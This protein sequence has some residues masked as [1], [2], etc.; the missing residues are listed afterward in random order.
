MEPAKPSSGQHRSKR[1]LGDGPSRGVFEKQEDHLGKAAVAKHAAKQAIRE[2][3]FGDAWRLLHDQ[4][5]EWL[6]HASRE[7]FIHQQMLSLLASIHKDMANVL[8]LEDKQGEALAHILYCVASSSRPTQAQQKKLASYFRRCKF[9]C[10]SD[11]QAATAAKELKANPDFQ[12]A[13]EIVAS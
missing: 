8:R 11:S 2:K 7:R 13:Q 5:C 12:A 1:D 4:Q 10:L 3:R 6:Q 9:R